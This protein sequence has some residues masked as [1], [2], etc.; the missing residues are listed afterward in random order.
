MPNKV[1]TFEE[2]RA[3]CKTVADIDKQLGL[4][5]A[6]STRMRNKAKNADRLEEK[7]VF[8]G[9]YK[10]AE[11]VLL[12]LRRAVFDIEDELLAA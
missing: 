12:Q 6:Y 1:P 7:L 2:R 5:K 4:A 8:Q 9:L 10:E 11:S 3:N